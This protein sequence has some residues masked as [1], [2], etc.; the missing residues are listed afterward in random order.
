[1]NHARLPS[2]VH[3]R[4]MA[5]H[6]EILWLARRPGVSASQARAWYTHVMAESLKRRIR[7]F[8][9]KVS[10]AAVAAAPDA[11]LRLEH[12]RRI[13]AGLTALVERQ[14]EQTAPDSDGF[15]DWLLQAEQV[16]I[17]TSAENYAALRCAGDYAA[18][19]I[20]LMEWNEIPAGRRA[21]LWRRMLRGR[22][23]NAGDFTG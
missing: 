11:A 9:G 15:V 10:R 18:A 1:M 13:Q 3:A 12:F 6:E 14:R 19:G 22:V 4:L 23:A 17:V 20:A 21:A 2:A 8:S 7:R 5:V 16:H